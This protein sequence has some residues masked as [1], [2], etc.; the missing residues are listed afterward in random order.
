MIIGI[1]SLNALSAAGTVFTGNALRYVLADAIY[2]ARTLSTASSLFGALYGSLTLLT[3][4]PAAVLI[5]TFLAIALTF[6]AL[7]RKVMRMGM[8]IMRRKESQS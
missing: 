7:H 6:P 1:T 3:P 2:N 4:T 5:V 8:E